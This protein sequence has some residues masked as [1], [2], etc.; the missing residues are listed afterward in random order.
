M[1]SFE[2]YR[3]IHLVIVIAAILLIF[4]TPVVGQN[5][6][7]GAAETL[8]FNVSINT[9]LLPAVV[10]AERL[11]DGRL[12]LA[13]ATWHA[14]HL[15][16]PA[17]PPL[18]LPDNYYG[19]ALEAVA[20]LTYSI[21][22]G[23]MT[24]S[25]TAPASAFTLRVHNHQ[26]TG[27]PSPDRVPQG[28]YVDYDAS[29]SSGDHGYE[30]HAILLEGVAF[31]HVGSVVSGLL[32]SGDRRYHQAIRT[33][34]YWRKDLPSPMETL[35]LGDTLGDGGA[36]S[37]PARYAGIRWARD[38][39]LRPGFIAMPMPS[40]SGTAALPS[41]IDVLIN[42]Q[43]RRTDQVS[44]GPFELTNV[45]VTNG[46]GEINLIVRDLLGRESIINQ[47]YYFSPRLVAK[48]LSD[49]SVEA[50][51]LRENYGVHSNDYDSN[52]FI[53]GT[54]R[55]GL[56]SALTA[57]VRFEAQ[58][59]RQAIGVDLVALL[60][61]FA[62]VEAAL[63]TA[64][65]DDNQGN[66]YLL[67]LERRTAAGNASL[68]WE[69]FDRDFVQFAALPSELRPRQRISASLGAL[70]SSHVS[71]AIN[72][73]VQKA[74]DESRLELLTVNFGVTLADGIYL[75]NYASKDLGAD[76]G[77]SAGISINLSLGKQRSASAST[78][79]G[80]NRDTINRAELSQSPP[81]GPG[82]G[83]R[84]AVSDDPNQRWRMGL[85]KNTNFGRF[86]ADATDTINDPAVRLG[87]SGSIG[88]LAGHTFA[89]RTIGAGSFAVVKVDSLKNIPIYR[90]NQLIATTNT[91]GMALIPD[92]L[93]YQQNSLT[94]D[95]I[96]LPFDIKIQSVR[97]IAVPFARSGL[98][99][100][101]PVYR[102][103]NALVLLRQLDG[104][105]V[106]AGAQVTVSPGETSFIVGKRGEAYLMDL[107]DSNHLTVQWPDHVCELMLPLDPAGPSEPRIGPVTCG[108]RP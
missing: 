99:V 96:E 37:R 94:I 100:N 38:F 21:D 31:S 54:G 30:S 57:E 104:S 64:K 83:W 50:G 5:T 40:L 68:R 74:W 17:D 107:T 97:E 85:S 84:L 91:S 3:Q 45:P 58:A 44:P 71:S 36:W 34:T 101:F 89:A 23:L 53:A 1:S 70:L 59:Q 79:T 80:S 42:N 51:F 88:W 67:G 41:T 98:V 27:V 35:V 12:A 86:R 78:S 15:R 87:A 63:A 18:R 14:A 7:I 49:F 32:V 52:G 43:R 103:R 8:L 105:V 93:P 20:G 28:F 55:Y 65:T 47:N 92:L 39:S 61:T 48:G 26:S 6:S 77:W 13:T 22:H 106:P 73:T 24:L 33:E 11:A 82:S 4:V 75:S 102:S 66:H 25:I 62:T 72:Y 76:K 56:S 9:Q 90:S 69:Y 60:G 81:G 29:I 108:E 95:P 16:L 19:Y 2:W 46:A 10:R